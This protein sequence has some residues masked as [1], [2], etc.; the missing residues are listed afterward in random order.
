MADSLADS[1]PE[2]VSQTVSLL[3]NC[4]SNNYA[5]FLAKT[6]RLTV[7]YEIHK[8]RCSKRLNT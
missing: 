8:K 6:D 2:T 4:K 3:P 7:F 1:L 5:Q